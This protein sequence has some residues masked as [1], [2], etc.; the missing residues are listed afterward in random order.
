MHDKDPVYGNL[1][2]TKNKML[3]ADPDFVIGKTMNFALQLLGDSPRLKPKLLYDVNNF[4]DSV[5]DKSINAWYS[6]EK[7]K[8]HRHSPFFPK[9]S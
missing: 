7:L 5:Q 8:N 6:L 2:Q 1:E 3:Q 9:V 4:V